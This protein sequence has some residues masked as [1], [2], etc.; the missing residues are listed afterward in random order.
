MPSTG[1]LLRRFFVCDWNWGLVQLH[2]DDRR[3]ALLD[4]VGLEGLLASVLDHPPLRGVVVDLL[5]EGGLEARLVRT[6]VGGAHAV[7]EGEHLRLVALVR[8]ED[9]LYRHLIALLDDG[10]GLLEEGRRPVLGQALHVVGHAVGRVQY[11]VDVLLLLGVPVGEVDLEPPVETDRRLQA[12]EQGLHV[13]LG[14][15]IEDA[16]VVLPDRAGCRAARGRRARRCA[17]RPSRLYAAPGG[18]AGRRARCR[19]PARRRGR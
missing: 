7:G 14:V 13:V 4:D 17:G 3:Q 10:D 15:G 18:S 5:G 9:D 16:G 6:S 1:A 12:R 19:P 2:R 8:L 11:L